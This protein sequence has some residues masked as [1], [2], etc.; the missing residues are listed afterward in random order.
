MPT[1]APTQI[2]CALPPPTEPQTVHCWIWMRIA[3]AKPRPAGQ[4]DNYQK[5]ASPPL[6]SQQLR[7]SP[8][9]ACLFCS[10]L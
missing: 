5:W 8:S 9:R 3:S 4:V 2:A 6:R 7:S 10:L 1:P